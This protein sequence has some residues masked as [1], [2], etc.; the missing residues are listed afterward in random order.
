MTRAPRSPRS[1]PRNVSSTSAGRQPESISARENHWLKRFRVALAGPPASGEITLGI[2]GVRL[3]EEALRSNIKVEAVLVSESGRKHLARIIP[4]IERETRL[5]ATSDALFANLAATET[6]QGVAAIVWPRRA[7]LDDLFGGHNSAKAIA[8]VSN[9]TLIVVLVGVQ[10]RSEE[11]TSELQSPCNLVCRL[12][13]RKQGELAQRDG[14][15]SRAQGRSLLPGDPPQRQG[16]GGARHRRRRPRARFHF[17]NDTAPT[18]I[19]ALSLR[20]GLPI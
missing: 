12:L 7:T 13:L 18:E 19:Y 2:E 4:G 6:T 9:S 17:F 14:R 15:P 8:K 5:L 11:H 10:D 1:S 3:V 20:D 16:R